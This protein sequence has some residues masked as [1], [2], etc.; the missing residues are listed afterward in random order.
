MTIPPSSILRGL[1]NQKGVRADRFLNPT[2]RDRLFMSKEMEAHNGG[3][4]DKVELSDLS[5][6]NIQRGRDHGLPSYNQY[7]VW[8]GLS[9]LTQLGLQPCTSCC[10]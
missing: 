3:Q 9:D 1:T 2:L 8:A 10:K 5:A 6:R 4:K 7:R